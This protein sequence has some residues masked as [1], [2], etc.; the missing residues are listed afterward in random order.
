MIDLPWF[1]VVVG[2]LDFWDKGMRIVEPRL[3]AKAK[4]VLD[5]DA[6][7]L[8]TPLVLDRLPD[9]QTKKG[10]VAWRF[11][12]WSLTQETKTEARSDRTDIPNAA[13]RSP[14]LD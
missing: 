9:L 1:A 7:E 14:R 10:V 13:A 6:I 2:A 8:A 4:I 3:E 5:T 12:G 11:P